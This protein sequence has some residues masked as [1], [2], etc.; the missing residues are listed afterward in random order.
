M[1][2][3]YKKIYVDEAIYKQ[4]KKAILPLK[5]SQGIE[6]YM[7]VVV[8]AQGSPVQTLIDE[9]LISLMGSDLRGQPPK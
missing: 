9:A 3:V 1:S 8:K 2:R 6:V 5:P 7:S 4:Y